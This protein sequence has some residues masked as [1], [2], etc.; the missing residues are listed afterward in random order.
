MY[1]YHDPHGRGYGL[2]VYRV[3]VSEPGG[4]GFDSSSRQPQVVAHQH[5]GLGS[6]GFNRGS[7]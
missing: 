6:Q 5:W 7:L 3:D 2:E 4:P 1:V